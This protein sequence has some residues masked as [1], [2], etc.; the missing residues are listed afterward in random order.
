[1][2]ILLYLILI[3]IGAAA[4]QQPS[5]DY[6]YSDGGLTE[7]YP[8]DEMPSDDLSADEVPPDG[9]SPTLDEL[10]GDGTPGE[11]AAPAEDLASN[12]GGSVE[13]PVDG[14]ASG[15]VAEDQTATGRM[16]TASEVRPILTVTKSSWIAVREWEGQD[17]V[18]FTNLLAWRCGLHE[19]RYAVNG[20]PDEVLAA[21]P[22]YVDEGA[23]NALKVEAILPYISLPLGSVQEVTVTIL[24]DDLSTDSADYTRQAIQLN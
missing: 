19:I 24:Y 6:D 11:D 5:Y 7:E 3:G 15:Y 8:A 12:D 4:S 13:P 9:G 22:C 1:M 23:P 20:G 10:F 14:S 2:D 18:Y 21:E 17:L 16:T